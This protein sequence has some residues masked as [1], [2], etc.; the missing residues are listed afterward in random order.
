MPKSNNSD[1]MTPQK[2]T[3]HW[4]PVHSFLYSIPKGLHNAEPKSLP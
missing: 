3:P 2:I 1:N 4:N